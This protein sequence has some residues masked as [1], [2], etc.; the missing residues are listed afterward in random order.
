M[1][2]VT[3]FAGLAIVAASVF[4]SVQAVADD[5]HPA[6]SGN[7]AIPANSLSPT[8]LGRDPLLQQQSQSDDLSARVDSLETSRANI[9]QKSKSPISLSISGWVDQQVTYTHQ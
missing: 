5:A 4:V 9:D 2:T 1:K 6:A 3:R 7:G 8:A